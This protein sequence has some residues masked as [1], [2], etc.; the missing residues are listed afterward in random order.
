MKRSKHNLDLVAAAARVDG[1]A[2]LAKAARALLYPQLIT[3]GLAGIVSR[4][5]VNDQSGLILGVTWEL[6]LWGRV[7]AAGRSADAMRDATAADALSARQSLAAL[8]A[9]LWYQTI[10][11]ERL[12]RPRCGER[13][14][15]RPVAP[16]ADA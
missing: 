4:D 16:G 12:R 9:T 15:R 5:E 6:D 13:R 10:K 1:A 2:A 14:L 11:T 7:R 8:V 3:T